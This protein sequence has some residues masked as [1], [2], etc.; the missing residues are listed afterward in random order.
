VGRDAPACQLVSGKQDPVKNERRTKA[1]W[2]WEARYDT[3]TS[4]WC[5]ITV[6]NATPAYMT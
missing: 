6:V 3:A 1:S 2:D 5:T 4:K